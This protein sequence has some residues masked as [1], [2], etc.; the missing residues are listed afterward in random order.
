MPTADTFVRLAQAA[1]G[2]DTNKANKIIEGIIADSQYKK[3]T[4]LADRLT[5]ILS[6]NGNNLSPAKTL[7]PAMAQLIHDIAPQ[8]TLDGFALSQENAQAVK[9]FIA[10]HEQRDALQQKGFVPRNRLMFVGPPGNGKTSLAEIIAQKLNL[11]LVVVRYEGLIGSFLG[12][13]SSRLS[14]VFD[15]ARQ[16][17]CVLFF[18]EFDTVGKDRGDIHETGEIKRVVSSLLLQVDALPTQTIMVVASNHAYLLDS[19]AWRR[20][21]L[22]LELKAP[23]NPEVIKYIEQ[24]Q[25]RYDRLFQYSPSII[26]NKLPRISYA[27]LEDFCNDVFRTA[28][29]EKGNI[30]DITD[31]YICSWNNNHQL[32]STPNHNL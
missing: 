27:E 1:I 6:Q 32:K 9:T 10:E 2:G 7:D 11:P 23:T 25:S 5:S 18:D 17:H 21:Q 14:K 13:T 31:R 26:A 15:Y 3:Q 29:V 16:R 12:Q 28:F 22:R 30:N 19:A 8:K 4:N 20:F 24:Y